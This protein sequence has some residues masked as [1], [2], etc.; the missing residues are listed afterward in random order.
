MRI[1]K[2]Y[3]IFC[4]LLPFGLG[5]D[6]QIIPFNFDNQEEH[7]LKALFD[8]Q[9]MPWQNDL[10]YLSYL[11]LDE[12]NQLYVRTYPFSS[13]STAGFYRLAANVSNEIT[14]SASN[15][16]LDLNG[17]TVSDGTNGIVINSNLN[18]I[19]IKNG[20]VRSVTLD[21][22]QIN[23]GCSDITIENVM[24]KQALVGIAC[25][26]ATNS[27]IRN[28]DMSSN[29]TGL[30]LDT[31][32]NILVENCSAVAN[33]QAGYDLLSS[34][35]CSLINCKAL[36][37][38]DGNNNSSG[39][40]ANVYGFVSRDGHG[41]L[42]E[43]CVANST[44]NLNATDWN[45]CIAGYA[46]LGTGIQCNKIIGCE[47]GNATA[48]PDGLA[49]ATGIFIESGM[50]PLSSLQDIQTGGNNSAARPSWSPDG[51][52]FALVSFNPDELQLYK[53]DRPTESA[54]LLQQVS[55]GVD[56]FDCDWSPDGEFILVAIGGG[57]DSISV[58]RFD[59]I[60]ERLNLVQ[61]T[62]DAAS[63]TACAWH[64]SNRF[65]AT[66][67]TVAG[68][69]TTI[70]EF[71]RIAQTFSSVDTQGTP[72]AVRSLNWHPSGNYLALGNQA[73]ASPQI[74]VYTF[75]LN[76]KTLLSGPITASFTAG[77][78]GVFYLKFSPDGN[79]LAVLKDDG[80][81][82]NVLVYTFDG[83]SLTL[84]A[85]AN[86]GTTSFGQ[87]DWSPDSNYLAIGGIESNRNI[88]I[89]NFNPSLGSSA[90]SEIDSYDFGNTVRGLRW[91]PDGGYIVVSG[92]P[93]SSVTARVLP[94]LSYCSSNLIM[95]NTV[96]C[97]SNTNLGVGIIGSSIDNMIIQNTVFGSIQNYIAVTNVFDQ[98][99]G[100]GPTLLQNI[101]MKNNTPILMPLDLPT[102]LNRI[103]SL[104]EYLVVN[105][106]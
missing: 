102:K 7:P 66:S 12:H 41:N 79:Y 37:S 93:V 3:F 39:D 54:T 5:L 15:V 103:E 18:N 52:Y 51:N 94:G 55:L 13:I 9:G 56:P 63:Q 27:L 72:S 36:S 25:D 43:N 76:T 17:H 46:L 105:L 88:V 82:N 53:W 6:A 78:F 74:Y 58:F 1:A 23:S 90:L 19:T 11:M 10:N 24:I 29:T 99:F 73:A 86:T 48:S 80:T 31:C 71:D 33:T 49:R 61:A 32:A 87:L 45:T 59:A 83:Q 16:T 8:T 42:F 96:Y 77:T 75:D 57:S 95:K 89:Y 100:I 44:E 104:A 67:D 50:R 69:T 92:S 98:R 64:P 101:E 70:F 35:T 38:G 47:A 34:M 81:G 91:S 106:L 85:S 14:I 84:L 20:T 26:T 30:Q 40:Q 2:N 68:T 4:I 62:S 65:F 28:C 22:I 97:N 21:G 60:N